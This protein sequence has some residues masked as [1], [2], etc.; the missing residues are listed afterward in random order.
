MEISGTKQAELYVQDREGQ[1][2]VLQHRFIVGDVQSC[3]MSLGELYQAGWHIDKDGDDL[4]LLPPDDS[5]RVPVFYKNKS[6]AI[7]AHVRCVQEVQQQQEEEAD[8]V[9]AIIKL[10]DNFNLD[11][12]NMWQTTTDGA[13]YLLTKRSRFADPR[14]VF[15]GLWNYRSTFYRKVG[16]GKWYIAEIGNKFMDMEEPFSTIPEIAADLSEVDILTVLSKGDEP[17][18]Y[19]GRILD[20]GG[21]EPTIDDE[22]DGFHGVVQLQPGGELQPGRDLH[23]GQDLR[24]EEVQGDQLHQGEG[25]DI[26]IPLEAE[27]EDEKVVIGE[28]ELTKHSAIRDLRN[29]CRYLGISQAGSKEKMFNRILETNMK[30][31]RRQALEV[32]QR[33]YEAEVVQAEVVQAA[34]RQPTPHERKLHEATHLPFRQWCGHCVAAKSKDNV[35][36]HQE[37]DQRSRPTVQ[38]DFG[39]AECGEVLIAVDYWTKACMAEVMSKKSVNV[40]GESLANFLGELGY[41]E[42]IEICCDNEPV[43]AAGVKLTKDIRTR[44]GLE[45]IVTCGKAYDKGRTSAAERYIRTI[46]NQAKCVI[47]FVE[48]KLEALIPANAVIQ[49]WAFQHGAWLIN[50]FHKSSVT[51]LTAFQC[52][53]GRPYRGRICTFGESVYG[54]D[55]KQSKYK[56][57]WRRGLWLGKDNFDHDLVAVGDNEVLRCKAVRKAS[58]EW[59]GAAIL[60]LKVSP[61]NLRRGSR[62]VVKPASL[63]PVDI[64]LLAGVPHDK[65]AED[66]R[67]YAE[68]HPEEDQELEK[69]GVSEQ[70]QGEVPEQVMESGTIPEERNLRSSSSMTLHPRGALRP[71]EALELLEGGDRQPMEGVEQGQ[72]RELPEGAEESTRKAQRLDEDSTIP[73]PESKK[74]KALYPPTFAGQV[75]QV[76]EDVEIYV[77]EEPE[78]EWEI[79]DEFDQIDLTEFTEKDGPPEVSG[80]QLE[81]LDREAMLK[82]V[83]KLKEMEVI[84]SIPTDMS[85][86]DAL[87]LDTKNVFDWRYRQ[88][89][90]TRRCRIVAREFKDSVS[91]VDTFAPTTPWSGVRTLLAMSTVMKLKVAVFDV[92]DA[93]LS[94]PQQEFVVIK[95]PEWIRQLND[96]EHNEEF[97][98][99]KRCLPGQRN[100]ALRWNDYFGTLAKERGFEAC[101]CIPTVYRHQ[102]RQMLMN[103]HIDDI[104]L[105]GSMEDVEW[106]ESE[107]NKVLK[108]KKDGPCGVG[109]DHTIMYLKR[110]L[111]FRNNEFYLRTNRKYIPKLAEMMEVVE[112]RNKTLPY[113]PGLDTYDPKAVDKKELL[114]EEN[115]KKFRSGIGICLYLAHD[116]ID[117]QY[118]V[119]ILSSYMSRPTKNAYCGLKKLACYLRSTADFEVEYSGSYEY[120]SIFDRWGQHE[121]NPQKRSKYNLE[122]FSDSDWATS[123]SSRKSTSAGMI[124]LNGLL[125]HSHSRSQTSIALP[126]CEAELL[127][128]TGLLAEGLQLKQLIRFCL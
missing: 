80:E 50:K 25:H 72:R 48:E 113:H 107:F 127:A 6:L 93:F 30:A 76:I 28:M 45:T 91:T 24:P 118:A 126:S 18:N 112:R 84:G 117:I 95:I 77:D 69:G 74:S 104:L 59:N 111:E 43:L 68:Q 5:M 99:L 100:A 4:S 1:G 60:S 22:D 119:K 2:V 51:G 106:F 124:F 88:N 123:K 23:A 105:V 32:A 38:V 3:I 27:I 65:D 20:E 86:D 89:Q 110:E 16:E 36:K 26:A 83:E 96:D 64:K 81:A 70:H 14:P 11:R 17:M 34:L 33:Q 35:H 102:Q 71:G 57:Q 63:P 46:R 53:H 120:Q 61:E 67:N 12:M 54:H 109:D 79:E 103:V 15:G 66:V 56:L 41:A 122:L 58:E 101:K 44:N 31:L 19:F 90:W 8:V 75:R 52:V 37:E 87:Q 108:M 97:W 114:N 82:E 115:A 128:A 47:S 39:H 7:R 85:T 49:A 73:E 94:V 92:S 9:R 125:I 121:G 13:P 10:N 21:V 40:I 98:M 62:T 42:P 116:R 78:V 29:G 55:A